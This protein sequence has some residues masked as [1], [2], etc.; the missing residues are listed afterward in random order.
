MGYS[1]GFCYVSWEN[2][3]VRGGRNRE[4]MVSYEHIFIVFYLLQ[5]RHIWPCS[6]P[7]PFGSSKECFYSPPS[8]P[9]FFLRRYVQ[10]I[11]NDAGVIARKEAQE[12]RA[13]AEKTAEIAQAQV[14][15]KE[16]F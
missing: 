9:S 13:E 6:I 8:I 14:T 1:D 4:R 5:D 11:E 7:P 12:R 15:M 3:K 16:C 10:Y 2:G